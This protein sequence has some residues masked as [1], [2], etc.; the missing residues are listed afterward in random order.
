MERAGWNYPSGEIRASDADRDRALSELGEAFRAGRITIGEF[1]E[2]SGQ[3]LASRTGR[4][5]TALLADLP[6]VSPPAPRV[7]APVA[8]S[9][10]FA[11]R[12]AFAAAITAM[13]CTA[14]AVGA[15]VNHGPSPEQ[16]EFIREWAARHG[17]QVP[18]G[19]PPNPGFDW[20]G[21]IAPAVIAV[22]LVVLIICLRKRLAR[23]DRS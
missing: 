6:P 8:A 11:S 2:R 20:V 21:T 7:A 19:F 4:E 9:H 18:R 14:L 12:T 17:M 22:L 23:E 1:D 13:C 16:Q 3:A 5:L 15:A 10:V